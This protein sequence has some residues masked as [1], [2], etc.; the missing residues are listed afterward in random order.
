MNNGQSINGML[1]ALIDTGARPRS[2]IKRTHVKS[3]GLQ[4]LI[5]RS[6]PRISQ[7]PN[8]PILNDEFIRLSIRFKGGKHWFS[9]NFRILDNDS[10]RSAIILGQNFLNRHG[11]VSVN[12]HLFPMQETGPPTQGK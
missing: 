12:D 3:M 4:K 8:G 11:I 9:G 5:E 6:D 10:I 7:T 1:E 2:W